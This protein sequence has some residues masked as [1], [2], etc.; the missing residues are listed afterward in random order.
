MKKIN[1]LVLSTLTA[2]FLVGCG[3]GS[4]S[5]TPTTT[6]TTA[7]PSSIGGTVA[8]GAGVSAQVEILNVP[9]CETLTTTSDSSGT[10]QSGNIS[11]YTGP[12]LLKASSSLGFTMYSF[13]DTVNGSVANITPFTHYAT[14]NAS[15]SQTSQSIASMYATC[16][17]GSFSGLSD[18]N[19]FQTALNNT[20]TTLRTTLSSV[21]PS[22]EYA[23]VNPFTVPFTANQTGYD[24]LLDRV[25][26][27]LNNNDTVIRLGS[28]ILETSDA[29]ITADTTQN[30]VSNVV[31]SSG[32]SLDGVNVTITL[33]N[34]NINFTPITTTT[35]SGS[36]SATVPKYRDYVITYTKEGYANVTQNYSSFEN[37]NPSNI[38]MF[39]PDEIT[40]AVTPSLNITDSRNGTTISDVTIKIRNGANNRLGTISTQTNS[41]SVTSTGLSLT[42]G[43]YTFELSKIGYSTKY[44]TVTVTGATTRLNFDLLSFNTASNVN[45]SAFA[46]I[47]V[48]WGENPRDVDSYL[49]FNNTNPQGIPNTKIYYGNQSYG[50]IPSDKNNPCATSNVVASLDLDD[51]TSYGPETTSICDGS[52]GPFEFKLH[53]YSGS[54]NIG[55]S[56]TSVELIT[57]NG[58]RYEFV[59]PTT[60]FA[61]Y[62]DVWNVFKI[63]SNQVVTRDN[64]ISTYTNEI[65]NLPNG[66]TFELTS[67]MFANKT[68]RLTDSSDG[69]YVVY[70]FNSSNTGTEIGYYSNGTEE[71]RDTFTWEINEDFTQML[72]LTLADNS[73]ETHTFGSTL[74][75]GTRVSVSVGNE[76]FDSLVSNYTDYSNNQNSTP[77]SFVS[78]KTIVATDNEGSMT[79]TFNSNGNYSES[80]TNPNGTCTG[81]W[82]DLGNNKIGVTC[83]EGGTTLTPIEGNPSTNVL[84]FS[85]STITVNGT[86]T[87]TEPSTTPY[88]MT[89]SSV[90]S[91]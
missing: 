29:E 72:N 30:I 39:T 46:T 68:Y 89:I 17:N 85:S 67:S 43:I 53:H 45:S 65:S 49:L 76:N 21:F 25:D 18:I 27:S 7:T 13:I 50:A 86:V 24:A 70:T 16:N 51:T 8:I 2:A 48:R 84:Q 15:R 54:S 40:T 42:P 33:R 34:S 6:T 28:T 3:G 75:N 82:I 77:T 56:P 87:I 83:E 55:A 26:M 59:A 20:V 57:R 74:N 90:S 63:D 36:Y 19:S 88:N 12:F 60:G 52:K 73:I 1:G 32:S 4:S 58:S 14:D 37:V 23:T 71:F 78:G 35:S 22:N 61:G 79:S 9:T 11:S 31:N 10:W 47:I 62:N 81:K 44:Q 66:A 64:T 41:D 38:V 5:E 91:L 80:F 69:S